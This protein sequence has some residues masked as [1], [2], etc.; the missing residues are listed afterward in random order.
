MKGA[1]YHIRKDDRVMVISGRDKGKIGKVL[2]IN[3]KKDRAVIE[4]VNMVKRHTRPSTAAPQ[5]GIIEKEG[6]IHISN[7]K[8]VCGKCS[9]AVRTGVQVLEDGNRVRVCKGCGEMIDQV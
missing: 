5:G 7:L 3:A 8:V 9:E 4:R 1:H 6:P 2:K